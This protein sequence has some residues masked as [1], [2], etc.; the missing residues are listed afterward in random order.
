[1]MQ[2]DCA[3]F[4]ADNAGQL[5]SVDISDG[6]RST[7]AQ[8]LGKDRSERQLLVSMVLSRMTRPDACTFEDSISSLLVPVL[9][10]WG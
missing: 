4:L 1:M 5:P 2:P 8:K 9:P 3:P 6:N 7:L 10:I